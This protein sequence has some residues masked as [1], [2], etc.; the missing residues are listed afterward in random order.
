MPL[1][2]FAWAGKIHPKHIDKK[3]SSIYA[4]K[5]AL[6]LLKQQASPVRRVNRPWKPHYGK[7][8]RG[9]CFTYRR[10]SGCKAG[11]LAGNIITRT[12]DQVIAGLSLNEVVT[13]LR[14][15]LGSS[16]VGSLSRRR[17]CLGYRRITEAIQQI[18]SE[19]P[20]EPAEDRR[21]GLHSDHLPNHLR[22]RP[23]AI[24]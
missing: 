19:L 18:S 10:S 12:D 1:F 22:A 6:K 4:D 24:A 8:V 23:A 13:K 16:A 17:W 3:A 9:G 20:A 7:P 15:N 2:R 14:G 11:I 21:L 5:I